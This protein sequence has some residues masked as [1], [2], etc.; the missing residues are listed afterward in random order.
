[1][2]HRLSF[3][4]FSNSFGAEQLSVVL[5]SHTSDD[6]P[7]ASCNF[8]LALDNLFGHVTFSL[9]FLSK[10]SSFEGGSLPVCAVLEM[11]QG[12][13]LPSRSAC[14]VTRNSNLAPWRP[15]PSF[16]LVE[17]HPGHRGEH[18]ALDDWRHARSDSMGKCSKINLLSARGEEEKKYK[19][20]IRFLS[21]I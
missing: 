17:L 7:E 18:R 6:A 2:F 8:L 5:C 3:L 4:R 10:K 15:F 1:M 9:V 16:P 11:R 14:G 12:R 20:I 19:K 21:K 13:P